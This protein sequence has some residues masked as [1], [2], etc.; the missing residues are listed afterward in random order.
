MELLYQGGSTR[1]KKLEEP[2]YVGTFGERS[3]AVAAP[4][5]WNCLPADLRTEEDTDL[6]KKKLKTFLFKNDIE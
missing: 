4:K 1:T 2:R 5:L 3:F 6:F